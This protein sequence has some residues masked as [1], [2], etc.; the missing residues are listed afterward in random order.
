VDL[1]AFEHARVMS[2]TGMIK[3]ISKWMSNTL[4]TGVVLQRRKH[5]IFNRCPRCNEWG[6]DKVHV[7][8]CWDIR[9][10][11]IRTAYLKNL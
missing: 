2:Q 8:I 11:I 5:R 4:A 10:E 9:A 7:L 6:E 1:K 3:F